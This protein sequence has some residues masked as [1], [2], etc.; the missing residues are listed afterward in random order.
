VG[1]LCCGAILI[2]EC[3]EEYDQADLHTCP[4][5]CLSQDECSR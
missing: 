2:N 1:V 3:C 5:V 4:H